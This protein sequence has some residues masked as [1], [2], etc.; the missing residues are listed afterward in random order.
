MWAKISP[1]F[2]KVHDFLSNYSVQA[3]SDGEHVSEYLNFFA[4][5]ALCAELDREA[6]G[7]APAISAATQPDFEK[8]CRLHFIALTRKPFCT[9]QF[10]A[11][12]ETAILADAM[13]LLSEHFGEWAATLTPERPVFRIYSVEESAARADVA[14]ARLSAALSEHVDL[15]VSAVQLGEHDLRPVTLY[16][17]LPDVTPDLIYLGGPAPGAAEGA[18]N[19]LSLT[20]P[21][22]QPM[23]ADLLRMEFLIEPGALIMID[24]RGANARLLRAYLRRPW[25]YAYEA[26]ADAHFFE[27]NDDPPDPQNRI[28]LDFCIGGE[29]LL[30]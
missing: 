14:R 15:S 20:A 12:Y 30:D 6:F 8:L 3:F 19:G 10:G 23:S 7:G 18:F 1:D 9:L 27:L 28:K 21:G 16:D 2:Q 29:W 24:G 5:E 4:L 25:S 13:R 22:R 17:M 26:A 11:G